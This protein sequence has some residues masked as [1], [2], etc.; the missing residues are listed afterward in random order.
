MGPC[1]SSGCRVL[2]QLKVLLC[3]EH[4]IKEISGWFSKLLGSLPGCSCVSG[5]TLQLPLLTKTG[6]AL[7]KC[8]AMNSLIQQLD[9]I[10]EGERGLR[11]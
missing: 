3:R 2:V 10:C 9:S 4:Q 8:R 1:Q 5:R 6:T 11:T 7:L